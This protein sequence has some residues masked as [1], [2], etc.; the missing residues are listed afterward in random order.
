MIFHSKGFLGGV[1]DGPRGRCAAPERQDPRN[2]RLTTSDWEPRVARPFKPNLRCQFYSTE[3]SEEP[4]TG[5]T[6]PGKPADPPLTPAPLAAYRFY[7]DY[8]PVLFSAQRGYPNSRVATFRH[9][10]MLRLP[11]NL[12]RLLLRLLHQK[13]PGFTDIVTTLRLPPGITFNRNPTR[14]RNRNPSLFSL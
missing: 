6:T 12:L 1:A 7:A 2:E 4:M 5:K 3:N 11:R 8:I 9:S 14:N 13:S 10:E